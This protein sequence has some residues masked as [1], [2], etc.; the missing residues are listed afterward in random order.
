M[1]CF[2]IERN[3]LCIYFFQFHVILYYNLLIR[4]R[5]YKIWN[6]SSFKACDNLIAK[7]VI[8]VADVKKII[9]VSRMMFVN[10]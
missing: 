8:L 4:K 2:T 10:A 6:L 9:R 5:K 7:Q 1:Y 3:F